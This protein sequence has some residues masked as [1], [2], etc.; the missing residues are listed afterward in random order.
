MPGPRH[1]VAPRDAWPP[2]VPAA[3]LDYVEQVPAR[4]QRVP[5]GRRLAHDDPDVTECLELVKPMGA[6]MLPPDRRALS[7]EMILV[8]AYGGLNQREAGDNL[9]VYVEGE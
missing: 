8:S 3:A 2:P 6:T 4:A 9:V 7:T 5:R 1:P